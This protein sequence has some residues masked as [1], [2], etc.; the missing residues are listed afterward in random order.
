MHQRTRFAAHPGQHRPLFWKR[1]VLLLAVSLAVALAAA[2]PVL[3][4]T[5]RVAEG[6]PYE[7]AYYVNDSGKPGPT[8]FIVG[9]VHGNEPAG[10]QAARTFVNTQPKIGKIVVI[11]E[12]NRAAIRAGARIGSHPGDLNRQFPRRRGEQ[13]GSPL[14]ESLWSLVLQMKPDYLFD[15]HEGYDFHKVNP[16][17]VGQTIIY[18]PKGDAAT[19][20]KVM[21]KAVNAG[22]S[23]SEHQFQLLRYP[24]QGSLARAAA[25]FTPAR[26]MI[27]ETS[28]Q[29]P[30]GVRVGQHVTMVEAALK[31]LDMI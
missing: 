27:L 7:T 13:P 30:L 8:V 12:A 29:Q 14:A 31:S 5:G 4:L 28:K 25:M 26:S 3:A 18:Y 17:S 22:I 19:L 2:H 10:Y 21:Q 24:V 1:P 6:T 11:P 16:E 9:G 20:A 15:L 23:R